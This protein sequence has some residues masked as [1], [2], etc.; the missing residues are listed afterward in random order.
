MSRLAYTV[1][2]DEKSWQMN[3]YKALFGNDIDTINIERGTDGYTKGIIF[4]HKQN[5][6]SYGKGKALS[7][8]LIYL[9]RFNR[10]G[11]PVPAKICLVSQNEQ[12]CYIY[13]VP[14]RK[15][16]VNTLTSNGTFL[17]LRCKKYRIIFDEIMKFFCFEK[18][19]FL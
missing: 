19:I 2:S 16:K 17:T 13:N 11:I 7:Q 4:E 10:D 12:K 8:A 5:V 18:I 9:A 6:T 3:F 14:E 1:L 15:D